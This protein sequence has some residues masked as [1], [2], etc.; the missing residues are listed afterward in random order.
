M[1]LKL[2]D[3]HVFLCTLFVATAVAAFGVRAAWGM[4]PLPPEPAFPI[5]QNS[6]FTVQL[7]AHMSLADAEPYLNKL[8][9]ISASL[10]HFVWESPHLAERLQSPQ[11]AIIS[12]HPDPQGEWAFTYQTGTDLSP[13]AWSGL[14][15]TFPI[16][17]S[18]SLPDGSRATVLVADLAEITKKTQ[19]TTAGYTS[20]SQASSTFYFGKSYEQGH[21]WAFSQSEPRFLK[22]NTGYASV[23][24]SNTP[25]FVPQKQLAP[26]VPIYT[27]L[28]SIPTNATFHLNSKKIVSLVDKKITIKQFCW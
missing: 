19:Q 12:F 1:R 15:E 11:T 2:D 10:T 28:F 5:P 6:A 24:W 9:P 27:S 25:S 23:C 16:H 20:F 21:I 3:F 4:L 26:T 14:A 17:Q 7:P 18:R 22:E 13:A 8:G